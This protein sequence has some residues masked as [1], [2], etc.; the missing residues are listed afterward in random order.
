MVSNMGKGD[1]AMSL[2]AI[3][4]LGAVIVFLVVEMITVSLVS[5]WFVGGALAA[6]LV[7]F[8]TDQIWIECLVFLG[9]SV[10]LLLLLRP[11][12]R[13]LSAKQK[14]QIT[15][16]AKALIGKRAVVT[17]DIDN[18][19]AKGAVQVNGQFWTAR[20]QDDQE[21]IAKDTVVKILDVDG[22]KLLVKKEA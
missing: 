8:L 21:K 18:L 5:I 20:T 9:V 6:F 13:K 2:E 17:E 11:M 12:A 10:V 14:D 4:W 7:S 3:L 19:R 22:V 16:G 1:K 15:T